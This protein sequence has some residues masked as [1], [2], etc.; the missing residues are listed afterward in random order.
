VPD[1]RALTAHLDQLQARRRAE[2]RSGFD[3]AQA[4]AGRVDTRAALGAG[5]RHATLRLEGA[6][7]RLAAAHPRRRLAHCGDRLAAV[8]FRR[9]TGERLGL[10]AGRLA[11]EGRHLRALSPTRVLERG[12]AVVRGP[13]GEVLRRAGQAEV[14]AQLEI[15]LAAGSLQARVT[16]ASE[17]EGAPTDE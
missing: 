7:R 9:P 5:V 15:S 10:A 4:R 1:R 16:A 12:Y 11:A 8:D 2:W 6:E 13:S 3:A 17:P 14:G